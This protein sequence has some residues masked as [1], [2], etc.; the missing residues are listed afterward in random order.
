MTIYLVTNNINGK[1]YIGKTTRKFN[2]RKNEH[3]NYIHK[4]KED[5]N[6]RECYFYNAVRKDS[7]NNFTWK[8]LRDDINNK[9][10]LNV[11]ETFMIMVHKTHISEGGYNMTWG[12]DGQQ[13]GNKLSD[14]T[15]QKISRANK[16]KPK[17]TEHIKNLCIARKRL[18]AGGYIS[19]NKGKITTI[20]QRRKMSESHK[21]KKRGPIS[22][23]HKAKI[24][25]ANIGRSVSA[26]QRKKMSESHRGK[27]P[28]EET[29]RKMSISMKGKNTGPKSEETKRKISETHR[30]KKYDNN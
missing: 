29:R 24:I 10:V 4:N 2:I 7:W 20:E 8:V 16:N 15:K 9:F 27:H 14:E 18:F 22:P 28:S 21:G 5:D 30:R 3:K 19:P 12:G 17:S 6:Y 11:M 25:M 23:E 26:E 13:Y 1:Q